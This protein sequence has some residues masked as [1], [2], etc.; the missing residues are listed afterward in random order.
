MA[1]LGVCVAYIV[2][3]RRPA[4]VAALVQTPGGLALQRFWATGWGFDWLYDRT[5]VRPFLW[6]ARIDRA[7]FIDAF[8][9]GLMLLSRLSYQLLSRSQT[10]QVRWYAAGIACGLIILIAI[11]VFV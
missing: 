11:A 7:D 3:R 1:V 10:G 2:F 5:L 8:Y 9:T 6:L 4:I